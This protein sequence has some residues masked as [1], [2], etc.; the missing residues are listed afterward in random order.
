MTS[1]DLSPW[2]ADWRIEDT[3]DG[4]LVYTPDRP[5][6]TLGDA[7]TLRDLLMTTSKRGRVTA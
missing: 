7:L 1:P 3:S 5:P 4:P 6:M 2:P